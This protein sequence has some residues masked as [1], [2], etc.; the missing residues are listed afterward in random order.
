MRP[1]KTK[2]LF[3]EQ[4]F[5]IIKAVLDQSTEGFSLLDSDG[6]Y[7][8][9]NQAFCD[10][11][12]YSEAELL[13]M[14]ISDLLPP[15]K[16]PKLFPKVAK[17]IGGE[18]RIEI[19]RKDATL[20]Q[21]YVKASSITHNNQTYILGIVNDI[22]SQFEAE[23]NF[24]ISEKKYRTLFDSAPDPIVI[25]DGEIILDLNQS[26]LT[27]LSLTKKE[28]VIGQDPFALLHPDDRE[29]AHKRLIQL[30]EDGKPIVPAE[31]RIKLPNNEIRTVLATPIAIEFGDKQAFMVNYHDITK[32]NAT[33]EQ[34]NSSK[35]FAENLMETANTMVVAFDVQARITTF[36]KYAEDLTGYKKA[37]VLGENWFDLFI[38]E[39]DHKTIPIIFSDVLQQMPRASQHENYIRIKGGEKRL[40][41]WSNNVM[42]SP[43]G[44]AQGVLS[45]GIDITER[46]QAAEA[47]RISEEHYRNV[48]QDQTEYIMRYLPDG[49]ITFV[50]DSFCRAFNT[51]LEEAMGKN[52]KRGKLDT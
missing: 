24:H 41:S 20:L 49:S 36:N 2:N 52:V 8:G 33:R 3:H 29:L 42:L 47:L 27:A 7:V 12:G 19:F 26:A 9:V 5:F 38:T 11:T 31:F 13:S 15:G 28:Q 34:L 22:T 50:N 30:K 18:Q 35:E 14:K 51:S 17:G 46:K 48:V 44:V 32:R 40:I 21:A 37:E 4:D 1:K 10:I 45:I 25:H 6:Q 39:L 43:T 16:Q 23:G